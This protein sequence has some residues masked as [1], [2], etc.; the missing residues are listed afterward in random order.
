MRR[1]CIAG[2]CLLALFFISCKKSQPI[3]PDAAKEDSEFK[4]TDWISGAALTNGT[5]AFLN[6]NGQCFEAASASNGAVVRQNTYSGTA[7]QQ[8]DV[9]S[10]GEGNYKITNHQTKLA[11]DVPGNSKAQNV[12]L[13]QWIPN[14]GN[15]QIWQLQNQGKFYALINKNSGLVIT[16]NNNSTTR[17]EKITQTTFIHNAAHAWVPQMVNL[18]KITIAGNK[19]YQSG[20]EFKL[21]GLNYVGNPQQE[22]ME[23]KWDQPA[24]MA[25]IAADFAY[26]KSLGT[27]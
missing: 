3:T 26:M 15:N 5:Y 10:L 25:A 2:A 12:Q 24:V 8:W 16:L 22:L 21:W 20:K 23:D 27:N 7:I 19:F 18:P 13:Q 11:L 4:K 6:N 17:Y 9:V 14:S 1:S